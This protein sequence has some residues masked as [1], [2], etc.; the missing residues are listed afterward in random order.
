MQSEFLTKAEN[1]L[2]HLRGQL[3]QIRTGR[4]QP[5]LVENLMVLVESYGGAKMQLK[6]LASITAP[7]SSLLVIQPYDKSILKDVE[8]ALSQNELGLNAAPKND[9]L[10]IVIPPLTQERRQQ[11]VKMVHERAEEARVAIR[12][13]RTDI[14]KDIES[15]KGEAGISEDDIKRQVDELQKEVERIMDT[16]ESLAAKKEDELMQL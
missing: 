3:Q 1:Y 13:L 10:H 6:E 14:K 11:F 12:N 7:D 5:S 16:I 2:K 8:R 9:A 4:A 15:L